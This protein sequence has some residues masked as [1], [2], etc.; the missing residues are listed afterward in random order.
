MRFQKTLPALIGIALACAPPAHAGVYCTESVTSVI[1]VADNVYFT[2]NE[3][4]PNW[5]EINPSWDAAATDRALALLTSARATPSSNLTFE[6]SQLSS[7]GAAVPT[8]SSP[9]VIIF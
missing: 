7:C 1:V 5:C 4:C 3:S 8:Y 6:W 2:T 9:G